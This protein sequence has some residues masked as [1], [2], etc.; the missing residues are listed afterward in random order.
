MIPS[1]IK[2]YLFLL[3]LNALD[4]KTRLA[5]G[6]KLRQIGD[7]SCLPGQRHS[8]IGGIGVPHYYR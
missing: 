1:N 7:I 8:S 3:N 2:M 5:Y 4:L 6:N